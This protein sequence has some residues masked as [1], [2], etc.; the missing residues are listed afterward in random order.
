LSRNG[1]PY[2]RTQAE[3]KF[4]EDVIVSLNCK[5]REP[6]RIRNKRKEGSFW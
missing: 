1:N 5:I 6:E 3:R 4:V 2:C